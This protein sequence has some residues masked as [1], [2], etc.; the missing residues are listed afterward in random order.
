[1]NGGIL[2]G[3]ASG[4]HGNVESVNGPVSCESG[5]KVAGR[6]RTVN[7]GMDLVGTVVQKGLDT[8]NGSISL[9]DS[10]VVKGDVVVRKSK[11][12]GHARRGLSIRVL[13]GSVIEGDIRVLDPDLSV[14]VFLHSGGKVKGHIINARTAD[15]GTK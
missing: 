4:V 7:G 10:S 1:V 6:I 12:S 8:Y 3:A 15:S 14:D 11:G 5:V 2:I 9:S 13:D